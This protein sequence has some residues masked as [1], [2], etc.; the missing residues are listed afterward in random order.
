MPEKSR[1][2]RSERKIGKMK[3]EEKIKEYVELEIRQ[4]QI[5]EEFT[6]ED[7]I[8]LFYALTDAGV[9]P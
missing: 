7:N 9:N 6:L 5:R 4:R 8:D 1:K 2:R 3:K